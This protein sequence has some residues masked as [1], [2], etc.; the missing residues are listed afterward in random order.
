MQKNYYLSL[1]KAEHIWT[2]DV[3]YDSLR[4]QSYHATVVKER[5]K[6]WKNIMSP[7]RLK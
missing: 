6:E 1:E 2:A 3:L 4:P 7:R 5:I